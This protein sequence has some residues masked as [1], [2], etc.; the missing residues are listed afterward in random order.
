MVPCFDFRHWP[1][2]IHQTLVRAEG[3]AGERRVID[4]L[5]ECPLIVCKIRCSKF[6]MLERV[7]QGFQ[8]GEQ[9]S[10]AIPRLDLA[11]GPNKIGH[12]MSPVAA[13]S[14]LKFGDAWFL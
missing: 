5:L 1:D 4:V 3:H 9:T 14:Q 12:F 8:V 2:L 10:L 6:E 13:P 11:G 7:L